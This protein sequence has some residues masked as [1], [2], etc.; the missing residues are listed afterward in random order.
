[1]VSVLAFYS[2]DPS[3]NPAGY[4]NYLYKKTKTN[5]KEAGVG[6]SLRKQN[7]HQVGKLHLKRLFVL[8]NSFL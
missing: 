7:Y 1:M 4:L 6:P 2:N 5:E 8:N 3:S